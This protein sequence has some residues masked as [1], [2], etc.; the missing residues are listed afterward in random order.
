MY[1]KNNKI[2]KKQM[3]MRDRKHLNLRLKTIMTKRQ[4]ALL[5]KQ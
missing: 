5:K 1:H 3:F 2:K 4:N